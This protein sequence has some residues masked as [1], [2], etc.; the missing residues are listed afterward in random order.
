LPPPPPLFNPNAQSDRVPSLVYS[1]HARKILKTTI[2]EPKLDKG[3]WV[4]NPSKYSK[5]CSESMSSHI[6]LKDSCSH[7]ISKI[8]PQGSNQLK[9]VAQQK[10]EKGSK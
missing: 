3:K 9:V 1:Y 4:A 6:H 2:P 10:S 5:D 8:H 7:V